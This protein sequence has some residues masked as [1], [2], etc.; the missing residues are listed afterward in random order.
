MIAINR[1]DI[2]TLDDLRPFVEPIAIALGHMP[3]A[4]DLEQSGRHDLCVV[5]TRLGGYKRVAAHLGLLIKR[6]PR[7]L[8]SIRAAIQPLSDHL[9]RMP[10]KP[11]LRRA[12]LSSEARALQSF[13]GVGAVAE[14]IGLAYDK[15]ARYGDAESLRPYIQPLADTL[16]RMPSQPEMDAAGLGRMACHIAKMGGMA[17]VA[18]VLGL[19]YR[20][21]ARYR[22]V[23]ELRPVL[24]PMVAILGRMPSQREAKKDGD[25]GLSAAIYRMGGYGVV[26]DAL[27]YP[28]SG[29]RY[30]RSVEDLRPHIEGVMRRPGQ[31]PRDGD[32]GRD[33]RYDIVNAIVKF[34]G[35]EAV[36]IKLGYR[37]AGRKAWTT[38]R[39][40]EELQKY[41]DE[42]GEMPSS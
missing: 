30:W 22:D 20:L 23:S 10:S 29:R 13:G 37:Y 3:S 27:G 15:P 5:V 26:A 7:S 11:E 14:K 42:I 40:R 9:G 35:P 34:G 25:K 4:D 31:M 32:L 6:Q 41:V 17:K 38:E 18:A 1:P 28:Y 12:G 8:D 21:P 39:L 33:G 24:D 36:A 16:G 19:S 2:R